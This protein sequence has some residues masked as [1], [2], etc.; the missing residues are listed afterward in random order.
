MEYLDEIKPLFEMNKISNESIVK[1]IN[2][3]DIFSVIFNLLTWI[4]IILFLICFGY[5]YFVYFIVIAF[6]SYFVSLI[7]ECNTIINYYLATIDNK[8]FTI[9]QKIGYAFKTDQLYPF[10]QILIM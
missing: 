5:D 1:K 2:C 4:F 7:C 6:I 3:F 10:L 9:E 8:R